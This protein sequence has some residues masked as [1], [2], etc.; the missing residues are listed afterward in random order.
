MRQTAHKV[1]GTPLFS[2]NLVINAWYVEAKEAFFSP[3]HLRGQRTRRHFLGHPLRRLYGDL[4][5]GGAARDQCGGGGGSTPH[6]K[7][8]STR[9]QWV[10]E[11]IIICRHK[12]SGDEAKKHLKTALFGKNRENGGPCGI[13]P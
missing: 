9:S 7:Y 13:H 2:A 1:V 3:S 6:T 4:Q 8:R 11:H 5:H 10:T 12:A